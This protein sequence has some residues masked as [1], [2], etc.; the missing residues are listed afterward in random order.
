MK[1]RWAKIKQARVCRASFL[2]PASPAVLSSRAY[3]PPRAGNWR[4]LVQRR[5][6]YRRSTHSK[7]DRS[8]GACGSIRPVG[9]IAFWWRSGWRGTGGGTSTSGARAKAQR[10]KTAG[11]KEADASRSHRAVS[12][13]GDDFGIFSE[14]S[15]DPVGGPLP[16]VS[17]ARSAASKCSRR[18]RST[19]RRQRLGEFN[20]RRSPSARRDHQAQGEVKKLY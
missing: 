14:T 12:A 5:A 19:G 18:V 15:D 9:A 6:A 4:R 7:P 16:R 20:A 11:E 1:V 17:T 2:R 3:Q 10:C 13:G 8:M